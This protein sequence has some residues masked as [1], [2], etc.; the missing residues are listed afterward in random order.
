MIKKLAFTSAL[1]LALGCNGGY[2]LRDIETFRMHES[3]LQ[4]GEKIMIVY[5]SGE[6]GFERRNYYNHLI[7]VSQESGDTVNVLTPVNHG[8]TLRDSAKV[9][10]FFPEHSNSTKL[11]QQDMNEL[12]G[13][14]T[15]E[16]DKITIERFKKVASDP[17]F[18][19]FAIND[20]PTVIGCVGIEK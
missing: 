12:P 3:A 5:S 18:D 10:S 1:S 14:D 20:F 13:I 6:P 19:E 9:F 15:K 11:M 2:E 7:V 4:E 17:R 16:L 8:I